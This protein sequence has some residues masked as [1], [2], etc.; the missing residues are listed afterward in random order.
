MLQVRR[1]AA[2][3]TVLAAALMIPVSV[4]VS[5][6]A[7]AGQADAAAEQAVLK[8]ENARFAA[9]IKADTAALEKL[10]ADELSY[11]HSNALVQDK[12]AFISDIKTAKIKYLTVEPSGQ[13]AR[14]FG[15]MA[16]VTGSASV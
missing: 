9:M 12:A 15:T 11:T 7:A 4:P 1:T 6:R 14:I 2:M 13:K 10:L 3:A 8:A 16:I 5:A